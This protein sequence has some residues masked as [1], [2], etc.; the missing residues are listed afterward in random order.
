MLAVSAKRSLLANFEEWVVARAPR[1]P[2]MPWAPIGFVGGLVRSRFLRHWRA[3]WRGNGVAQGEV[4]RNSFLA[5]EGGSCWGIWSWSIAKRVAAVVCRDSRGDRRTAALP[6]NEVGMRGGAGETSRS[7]SPP[8]SPTSPSATKGD[9]GK[10]GAADGMGR[11]DGVS[12]LSANRQCGSMA[13]SEAGGDG[14][15][16]SPRVWR[17]AAAIAQHMHMRSLYRIGWPISRC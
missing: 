10:N 9:L 5:T 11:R 3:T 13:S 6:R 15:R 12:E 8:R 17:R 1:A 7:P 14:E 16:G 2:W 4:S